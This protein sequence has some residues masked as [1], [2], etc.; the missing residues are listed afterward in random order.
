MDNLK[1]LRLS[2]LTQA[3][4][5]IMLPAYQG[6]VLRGALGFALKNTSC[7]FKNR[8]C[9]NCLLREKCVYSYA[10]ET[11]PPSDAEVMRLYPYAPHPFVLNPMTE[12]EGKHLPGNK[13]QFGMTLVGRAIDYLPYFVYA[14]VLMGKNGIGKG[15]GRFVVLRIHALDETGE[16]AEKLY[17][18]DTLSSPRTVLDFTK[19]QELSRRYDP[20]KITIHFKTPLR[21]KY[22]GR[23]TDTPEFHVLVRVLLRRLSNLLY[24]HCGQKVDLPFKE[25]IQQAESVAT[26]ENAT[27]WFDW[28]RFSLRQKSRMKMGGIVG[29]ATYRGDLAD[30][31]PLLVAGSWLNIGK[32]T[33]FGL[34]SYALA[35]GGAAVEDLAPE[36]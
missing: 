5:N 29:R 36:Y 23:L 31:L 35:N 22:D 28:D 3:E 33:S 24:F 19:A 27:G 32:G 16:K 10:F 15:R 1:C 12:G 4:D 20:E 2:I 14:F 34:G 7:A 9:S 17:E 18:N 8:D 13:L 30:F 25:L 11:P 26:V 21:M 6:G